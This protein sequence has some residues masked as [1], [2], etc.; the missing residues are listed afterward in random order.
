VASWDLVSA[1]ARAAAH[2]G[3]TTHPHSAHNVALHEGRLRQP[4]V[5]AGPRNGFDG[6]H[7]TPTVD[8]AGKVHGGFLGLPPRLQPQPIES[9]AQAKAE[10][11]RGRSPTVGAGSL[12]HLF[13][14][15]P[16]GERKGDAI[17][18]ALQGVARAELRSREPIH[19]DPLAEALI[20]IGATAG[21]GAG[22]SAL[23]GGAEVGAAALGSE[24]AGGSE[25]PSVVDRLV[26]AAQ[27]VRRA[28]TAAREA[29]AALRGAAEQLA[30]KEGAKAA[31]ARVGGT[32]A[33][34]ALE[35]P[36]ALQVGALGAVGT[37]TGQKGGG[38]QI[39]TALVQGTGEALLH[40]PI[41]T[42][43]ATAR[44]L[45]GIVTAPAALGYALGDSILHGTPAPLLNTAKGQAEGTLDILGKLAS[46][47]PQT[48]R[49]ATE[50]EV[51][52]SLLP[53]LPKVLDTE[54]Y[55]G[56]VREP[57]RERANIARGAIN[58]A[59]GSDLRHIDPALLSKGEAPNVFGFTER[60]GE[61][62]GVA[63]EGQHAV[64]PE[65]L[66][67]HK[68]AAPIEAGARK[69]PGARSLR[70]VRGIQGADVLQTIAEYGLN[71]PEQ[72]RLLREKGPKVDN[73]AAGV[74][75][76]AVLDHLEA[77]PEL[78]GSDRVKELVGRLAESARTT[79]LGLRGADLRASRLGQ[80]ALF[81]VRDAVDRVPV[82]AREF[83]DAVD[84]TG[85]WEDLT[86][87]ETR[88]RTLRTQARV[89]M[90][91]AEHL[92]PR[93][94]DPLLSEADRA[95]ARAEA[96]DLYS[97][98]R[99]AEAHN[100]EFRRALDPYT[101]PGNAVS[102]RA[103]RKLWDDALVKEMAAETDAAA[104]AHGLD[105]GIW[106]SHAELRSAGQKAVG[107]RG[108]NVS[109]TGV[110]HVRRSPE[111]P[112][113]LAARD[114]VDR[115]FSALLEHS[116][117]QPRRRAGLQKFARNFF[118][119]RHVPLEVEL[120]DGTR[121]RKG[122]MTYAQ[123]EK[124]IEEGQI[125]KKHYTFVP[126]SEY[127]QPFRSSGELEPKAG[128]AEEVPAHNDKGAYGVVVPTEAWKEYQ[129]Q[130]NPTAWVGEKVVNGISKG[131]GRVLLFSP[132]WVM[133]QVF[134][135]ALPM[136]MAHPRLVL[137]PT[138]AARLER[139]IRDAGKIDHEA[140]VGWA[141]SMGEAPTRSATA[142]ELSPG[143][144][145]THSMFYDGARAIEH[146]PVGR[147]LFSTARL[148]PLV[149]F[150][151]WRQGKYRKILAAAEADSR[152]NGYFRGLSGAIRT[153]REISKELRG[154]PLAEAIVEMERNPRY[155]KLLD[156]TQRYVE[157]IAGNWTAFTRYERA[158]AP[159]SIFYGFTRYA[160]RWPLAFA[161][162]HPVSATANYF[163]AEQ[164]ANQMEKLLGGKP[165]GGEILDFANPVVQ[166]AH[167]ETN[168]LPGGS[169]IA[170]GLSTITQGTLSGNVPQ[171]AVGS[172]N[173]ALA[174][175]VA[176][177]TGVDNFGQHHDED[178]TILGLDL[179]LGAKEL[180][181]TPP[182][183]R[184]LGV[185]E[186]HSQTAEEL[187]AND[188]NRKLRS[189]ALPFLPQS[190]KGARENNEILQ[191][192]EDYEQEKA[193]NGGYPPSSSGS[194][195]DSF[196]GGSSS[197]GF[198]GFGGSS[199]SNGFDGF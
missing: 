146:T 68:H 132:A 167:G 124:A 74:T 180:M 40:N 90:Q 182:L 89:K 137:D 83:T 104:A 67:A 20:N 112:V 199:S 52:L 1:I 198:S 61:R 55:R 32:A 53:L 45:A 154:K 73:S 44:G 8:A 160:L 130:S 103:R 128:L 81:G 165:A 14:P 82:R 18:K 28:P 172:L 35:H 123:Y 84:R 144:Q 78:L 197:N 152:L 37:A 19:A 92:D 192:I 138:Y 142:R 79:P 185:G 127:R 6:F 193:E 126:E 143:Y 21:L 77:H 27:A 133:S 135:E 62:R 117:E 174:S 10:A 69:L 3:N 42:G 70:N 129:A 149:V 87:A 169:R 102:S 22:V 41:G 96:R 115:S 163:L 114:S 118:S 97:Q 17:L 175:I 26:K 188:P 178:P 108:A 107:P 194:G 120:A 13:N 66:R 119:K 5:P 80:A 2:A 158:F 116:V 75:L 186:S 121:A 56:K 57:L 190:G 60:R 58:A 95:A 140:A 76:G 141:A 183:L 36:K 187:H 111:D 100:K 50:D 12:V 106:T 93:T 168:I 88:A 195:F 131:A 51:G 94:H 157:D 170:P 189:F 38:L 39:P 34:Q 177:V 162:R 4:G 148:R 72:L 156:E 7:P 125:S 179:S 49:H 176:A 59:T 29:P 11:E 98:A 15:T 109:A 25:T 159:F 151:Q 99:T 139:Q 105:P 153:E 155:R 31:A 46:G 134:A 85:A 91:E 122:R 150:D 101:R 30:T 86:K 113:S 147:A 184:L 164:N 54:L 64:R 145:P 16:G 33:G 43:E 161:R 196:G 48:V 9:I 110:Q 171:A 71:S 65:E 23:R 191:S 63:E 136:L 181:T 24:A 173:P 166:G 47:N